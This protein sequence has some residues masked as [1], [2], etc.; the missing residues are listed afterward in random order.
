MSEQEGSRVAHLEFIQGAIH[1]MA[2]EANTL[3]A[4]LVPVVTAAYGLAITHSSWVIAGLGIVATMVIGWQAACY[5]R[6]E[7]AFRDLY[8][9]ALKKEVTDFSMDPTNYLKKQN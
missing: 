1:R 2:N 3:K 9:A 8:V 4:W 5:L 6:R 7:R